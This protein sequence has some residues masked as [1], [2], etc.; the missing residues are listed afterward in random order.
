[1]PPLPLELPQL[2]HW[3]CHNCAGCC[4]QHAIVVTPEEQSRIASQGWEQDA[5]IGPDQPLFV[6]A[7]LSSARGRFQLAHRADGA[8]VFLQEDGLCR[9][10]ARFGEAAKPAPCRIYPYAF[11]PLGPSLGVSLRYSCPSVVANRGRTAEENRAE[12]QTLAQLVVPAGWSDIPPPPVWGRQQLSWPELRRLVDHVDSLLADDEGGPIELKLQRIAFWVQLIGQ[13]NFDKIRGERVTELAEVISEAAALE[14]S[15]ATPD[16]D[17]TSESHPAATSHTDS[18]AMAILPPQRWARTQ[19][20]LLAMQYARR[21]TSTALAQGWHYRWQLLLAGLQTA[22]GRG[23]T[24]P[25]HT[26]FASVPFARLEQPNGGLPATAQELLTRYYRTKVQS[27]S[28]CG[29]AYYD[30]PFAEGLV[31]L[32]LTFPA[33]MYLTRWLAAGAARPHA[34]HADVARALTFVDHQH[35]YSPIFGQAAFRRRVRLLTTAQQLIP[36]IADY[37]R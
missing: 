1:M 27:L 34:L 5:F 31:S 14:L 9:I 26:D 36:L 22:W 8:C 30:V 23:Q 28:F 10:H 15:A 32:L 37:S 29:R 4:R 7:H 19:L 17:S 25:V 12:L 6:P 2:Q 20:R 11:H 33:L 21:D 24:H 35:G 13:A 3:S 16:H 18:P